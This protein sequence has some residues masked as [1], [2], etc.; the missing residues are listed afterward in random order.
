MVRDANAARAPSLSLTLKTNPLPD[1]TS[2][3]ALGLQAPC[4]ERASTLRGTLA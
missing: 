3:S 1:P 2:A 4:Q